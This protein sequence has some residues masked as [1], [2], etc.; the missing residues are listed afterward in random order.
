MICEEEELGFFSLVRRR[1][2]GN[3][4]DTYNHLKSD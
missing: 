2:R 1:L 4:L 3:L